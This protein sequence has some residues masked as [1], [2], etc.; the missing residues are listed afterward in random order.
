MRNTIRNTRI[1]SHMVVRNGHA[2]LKLLA[3]RILV[4]LEQTV[5][6]GCFVH[7]SHFWLHGRRLRITGGNVA[8]IIVVREA[9][10]D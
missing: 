3:G 10:F 2:I 5:Q 7:E 9:L 8:R 1:M 6:L 4:H